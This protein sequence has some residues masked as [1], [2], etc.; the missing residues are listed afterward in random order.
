[1]EKNQNLYF[2]KAL[3]KK[4]FS[5]NIHNF[6]FKSFPNIKLKEVELKFKTYDAGTQLG[7]KL[8]T[9]IRGFIGF[10]LE[11]TVKLVKRLKMGNENQKKSFLI[12]LYLENFIDKPGNI[13]KLKTERFYYEYNI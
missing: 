12:D 11:E 8:R 4:G 13:Q 2:Y 6:P 7:N 10:E 9:F 1:M 3:R 5:T